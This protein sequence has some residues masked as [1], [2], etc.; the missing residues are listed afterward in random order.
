MAILHKHN[1]INDTLDYGNVTMLGEIIDYEWMTAPN[2][3]LLDGTDGCSI[4]T[5][6]RKEK[7]ILYGV[8]VC[9]QLKA[10]LQENY[11]LFDIYKEFIDEYGKLNYDFVNKNE[12]IEKILNKE[13]FVL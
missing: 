7:E 3:K 5:E 2:I 8:E 11:N 10:M 9:L 4:L 13:K 12:R 6:E 1:F